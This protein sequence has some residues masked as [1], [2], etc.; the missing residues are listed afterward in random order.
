[1]AKHTNLDTGRDGTTGR[2]ILQQT[3]PPLRVGPHFLTALAAGVA[4]S[5]TLTVGAVRDQPRSLPAP[6][7]TSTARVNP[8]WVY[9]EDVVVARSTPY[10]TY[11]ED[12]GFSGD[13]AAIALPS[14]HFTY[15]DDNRAPDAD[16]QGRLYAC[17]AGVPSEG[18]AP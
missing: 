13:P 12:V 2:V 1:M 14:D 11:Q 5:L 6:V 3:T 18:C 7:A 9:Y 16:N 8:Y 17:A 10:W 15:R 4:L